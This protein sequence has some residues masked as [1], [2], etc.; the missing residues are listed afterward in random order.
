MQ[1]VTLYLP[2]WDRANAC[3]PLKPAAELEDCSI[4]TIQQSYN[5][6][7]TISPND[8]NAET[9][10]NRPDTTDDAQSVLNPCNNLALLHQR[11]VPRDYAKT[12]YANL[13]IQ[14]LMLKTPSYFALLPSSD[15]NHTGS[16]HLLVYH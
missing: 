6:T 11:G 1:Y 14:S 8:D 13:L 15:I 5:H 7:D 16:F 10:I 12:P 2:P 9:L 4:S 3:S